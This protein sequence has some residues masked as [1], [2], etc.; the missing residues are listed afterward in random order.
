MMSMTD[1]AE[2]VRHRV[3]EELRWDPKLDA[4]EIAVSASGGVV[5]LRGT[6]GT[7]GERREAERAAR[8][9]YG[10]HR[11]DNE[12]TV[13]ILDGHARDDAELRGTVLQALMLDGL[14]PNTIDATVE[15]GCVTLTGTATFDHERS[16]AE[17]VA[18]NV[19]GVRSVEDRVRLTAAT[20]LAAEVERGI[21]R[22]L[23]RHARLRGK[24]LSVTAADG[25]VTVSGSVG[26]WAEHDQAI[27]SVW[28]SPGVREVEDRISVVY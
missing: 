15:D 22:A 23:N 8:R 27:E 4:A 9:V 20:P 16:E 13:R 17:Y 24:G 14:V 18:A 2:D 3:L 1:S 7:L 11:V 25:R 5:T 19:P 6:V 21:E 26:S 10:V 28:A 12:L